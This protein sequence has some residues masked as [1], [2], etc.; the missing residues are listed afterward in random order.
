MNEETVFHLA[1]EKPPHERAAFLEAA[2]AGDAQM[3]QRVEILLEADDGAGSFLQTPVNEQLATSAFRPEGG[4]DAPSATHCQDGATPEV[5]SE[6]TLAEAAPPKP[7]GLGFLA[8][9]TRPGSIGRLGHYEILEVIGKGGFGTVLKAFDDKLH[10]VVAIKV[11]S[12]AYADNGSARKRF[13]RE[14]RTAAA[15]KNEHVVGIYDVDE[16]AQPPYLAMEMIEGISLQDKIDKQG[17]LGIREILRIGMQ[18]AEGLAAAH[19]QGLVHRDIKPANILLENGVERVKITDFGLARAVDDASVTQSGTVAGTPMFMSPEQA[20]GVQIDHRSDLFSLGTVLYA[21]CTGHPPFRASG[22]HAV[23]KRVID[24]SPRPIREINNDI[25]DWLCDII[26]KLHA[27]QP[28]DRFQTAREVAE[29]LSQHL[30]HLQQPTMV[31]RPAP[32]TAAK[33]WQA[34]DRVW[35]PWE[36]EWLYPG[37]IQETKDNSVFVAYDDGA[38]EWVAPGDVRPLNLDKGTR[39]LG[40]RSRLFRGGYYPATITETRGNQI[41]LAYDA[42]NEEWTEPAWIRIPIDKAVLP[43]SAP[44]RKH[45]VIGLGLVILGIAGLIALPSIRVEDT[46][47]GST[48]RIGIP[49]AWFIWESTPTG[50]GAHWHVVSWSVLLGVVGACCLVCGMRLLRTS[51]RAKKRLAVVISLAVL[52]CAASGVLFFIHKDD[53]EQELQRNALRGKWRILSG[54]ADGKALPKEFLSAVSIAFGQTFELKIADFFESRGPFSL[55]G[56]ASPRTIRSDLEKSKAIWSGKGGKLEEV[57]NE[58]VTRYWLGH[59]F[60]AIYELEGNKLKLC[61]SQGGYAP[62]TRFGPYAGAGTQPG[63]RAAG[64]SGAQFGPLYLVLVRAPDDQAGWVQLFNGKDLSGWKTHPDRPGQWK[65][66]NGVLHGSSAQGHLFSERGDFANFHLRMETKVN[67]GGDGSVCFRVPWA[68]RQ[69]GPNRGVSAGYDVELQKRASRTL[70]TGSLSGLAL[71][72]Q[73]PPQPIHQVTDDTLVQADEWFM[74][75][76]IAQDDHFIVKING[77]VATDCRDPLDRARAGHL[78]MQVFDAD[79]HVQ[80]KKIEI[81]ELPPSQPGWVQLFNGKDHSGWVV[82][83]EPNA[84]RPE[85]AWEIVDNVL[86]ARGSPEGYLRTEKAYHRYI[87][88]MECQ[89][90]QPDPGWAGDLLFHIPVPDPGFGKTS[91]MRLRIEPGRSGSFAPLGGVAPFALRLVDWRTFKPDWNHLRV[92]STA[93]RFEV[94]LNGKSVLKLTEFAGGF[95]PGYF[96]IMSAGGTGMRYRNIRIKELPPQEPRT[97]ITGTPRL[98]KTIDGVGVGRWLTFGADGNTLIA[99][100]QDL[101]FFDVKTGEVIHEE[102]LPNGVTAPLTLSRDRRTLALVHKDAALLFDLPLRKVPLAQTGT[103][104]AAAIS[105]DGKTLA[106]SGDKT[107]WLHDRI[108]GKTEPDT[109]YARF[110]TMRFSPDGRYLVGVDGNRGIGGDQV[111]VL[112]A[113]TRA[114]VAQKP[115][116]N[117]GELDIT[118]DGKRLVV[119]GV[120]DEKPCFS[121]FRLPEL[122]LV[123]QQS[124]LKKIPVSAAFSPDGNYLALGMRNFAQIWDVVGMKGVASW[125]PGGAKEG[126]FF[127]SVAFSPDGKTLATGGFRIRLWDL[128]GEPGWVQ[129]FNGKDLAGWRVVGKPK[130]SWQIRDQALWGG[131]AQTCLVSSQKLTNFHMKGEVRVNPGCEM[132]ILCQANPPDNDLLARSFIAPSMRLKRGPLSGGLSK[133]E[134]QL[135][136]NWEDEGSP[137]YTFTRAFKAGEWLTFDLTA[138]GDRLTANVDIGGVKHGLVRTLDPARPLQPGPIILYLCTNEGSV[139]FR[140]IDIK[141]LPPS[142]PGWVQLF[143]GKDLNGWKGR[144]DAWKIQQ[145]TLIAMKIGKI[146]TERRINGNFH[147]RFQAKMKR[148]VAAIR[149]HSPAH[150]RGWTVRL[151]A[152]GK[153]GKVDG[154]LAPEAGGYGVCQGLAK[155]DEWFRMEIVAID[156]NVEVLVNGKPGAMYARGGGF[157][158]PSGHIGLEVLTEPHDVAFRDIEI[159]ELPAG[160]KGPS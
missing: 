83:A 6:A 58:L 85:R 89:A 48:F 81:K 135:C 16:K 113:K 99:A 92:E 137:E 111:C 124:H 23:L 35:A 28:E 4:Q 147:L 157:A 149:L 100:G 121:V 24:A 103:V 117:G 30:A 126:D 65:V 34:G 76:I 5:K 101:K 120:M 49:D 31:S 43:A 77:K 40:Y 61:M 112:D 62:P 72:P 12:P 14:A 45:P 105:P 87:L 88:E 134:V 56:S 53:K 151:D 104:Y 67:A 108:S 155:P 115:I 73:D 7:E 123:Y 63:A 78:V 98:L 41:H 70:R 36:T 84:V 74:M 148:G 82:Q 19:K 93:G 26:G 114:L 110:S 15:V 102:N 146:D 159:K 132:R 9:G 33:R 138:D 52:A 145:N 106:Y 86:I 131:G 97:I 54:E 68:L 21:M 129:L 32:V 8:P 46:F 47:T 79:T 96:G 37:T 44:M 64:L 10:R 11:L 17:P 29:L 27:K 154:S 119:T 139:E 122:E 118:E 55:D 90:S 59:K 18:M 25:P 130:N 66:I 39:V 152:V 128:V 141:E 109:R 153:T 116:G 156:N 20:E 80:F 125:S 144:R 60:Q 143:N 57:A 75:E 133:L 50:G 158:P 91:G 42:G 71:N 1:R 51:M 95:P 2:C 38:T 3:R 22:T 142:K 136:R 150:K 127:V 69:W 13:I 94:L 160:K 107:L 140:R